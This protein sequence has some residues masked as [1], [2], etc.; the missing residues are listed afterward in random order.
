MNLILFRKNIVLLACLF[1]S[2]LFTCCG[3]GVEDEED[4]SGSSS[5]PIEK[6][7]QV[8]VKSDQ[9]ILSDFL[10]EQLTDW[11][12]HEIPS[13]YFA[14]HDV[15]ETWI[16]AYSSKSMNVAS[17][18]VS[19][20]PKLVFG[21][22]STGNQRKAFFTVNGM[23]AE[24][25][26][27]EYKVVLIQ[28]AE[29]RSGKVLN[30]SLTNLMPV[31]H[32]F[33]VHSPDVNFIKTPLQLEF[34]NG[35]KVTP[36]RCTEHIATLRIESAEPFQAQ[37]KVHVGDDVYDFGI[38]RV[39]QFCR[40]FERYVSGMN[41]QNL[42]KVDLGKARF[43]TVHSNNDVTVTQA[44]DAQ[45][46]KCD[47]RYYDTNGQEMRS[48]DAQ[49]TV[50]SRIA[51]DVYLCET[52]RQQWT[53]NPEKLCLASPYSFRDSDQSFSPLE[54][55]VSTQRYQ[56]LLRRSTGKVYD[57]EKTDIAYNWSYP[58]WVSSDEKGDKFYVD[59]YNHVDR[60]VI[61]SF[62]VP[63]KDDSDVNQIEI[64]P[65]PNITSAK[66][67]Y[68]WMA[69][70]NDIY[71]NEDQIWQ[72]GHVHQIQKPYH[73]LLN[74]FLCSFSS[75]MI[76][77]EWMQREA[78]PSENGHPMYQNT[79]KVTD[80]CSDEWFINENW[81]DEGNMVRREYQVYSGFDR[82]LFL[83]IIH[84]QNKPD[85][86]GFLMTTF[87]EVKPFSVSGEQMQQYQNP[88]LLELSFPLPFQG[89][90]A[91]F[92]KSSTNELYRMQL[93]PLGD[94]E[95]VAELPNDEFKAQLSEDGLTL[96]SKTFN[97]RK[98]WILQV[99]NKGKSVI[100]YL[101]GLPGFNSYYCYPL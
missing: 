35:L 68:N 84:A 32:T 42:E 91:Y 18:T 53:E 4:A 27:V 9:F 36:L 64:T 2:F 33:E 34:S 75:K 56:V 78:I 67:D 22:N 49:L 10:P 19:D 40:S 3:D 58:R 66:I 7:I 26:Y 21:F 46:Q 44:Y 82:T 101:E 90:Y 5:N 55:H 71:L 28:H 85:W 47:V 62:Y 88:E 30:L 14:D 60:S 15:S 16:Y 100:R 98:I 8:E 79:L 23:N 73:P 83:P 50:S 51:N 74:K 29:T 52:T 89:N 87:R 43:M 80:P 77:N 97:A 37:M 61:S 20:N 24:G 57:I 17:S 86:K 41:R 93:Y 39:Y 70:D 48:D 96:V 13:G 25:E 69:V 12:V 54:Y 1:F 59:N 81:I 38:V 45:L 94:M 6:N 63:K 95:R 11:V 92:F 99:P 31:N 72:K 65:L 76:L